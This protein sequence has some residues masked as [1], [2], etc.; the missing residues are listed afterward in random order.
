MRIFN[1]LEVDELVFLDIDAS[2]KGQVPQYELLAEIASECFMPLAY[3]GGV[4]TIEMAR[5]IFKIG[6]EKIIINHELIENKSFIKEL[7]QAFGSQSIIGAVDIKKGW[8]SVNKVYS[9]VKKKTL[10]L[11]PILYIKQLESYGVGELLITMVEK[12]GMFRGLDIPLLDE[13]SKMMRIPVIG[14]GGVGTLDDICQ[15][16][17]LTGL[18]AIAVGSFVVYQNENRSVLI[19]YP[20]QVERTWNLDLCL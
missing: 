7:V 13:I 6:F 16:F 8:F 5:K 15:G 20:T 4:R 14:H 12:E 10:D 18:S 17:A 1:E 2:K 9:H 11:D 19:N 3:G